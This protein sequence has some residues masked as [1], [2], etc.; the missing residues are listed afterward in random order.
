MK[1]NLKIPVVSVIW[2]HL[3]YAPKKRFENILF[4]FGIKTFFQH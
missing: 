3:Q 4:A 1:L 2:L